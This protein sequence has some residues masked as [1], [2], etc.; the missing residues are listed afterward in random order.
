MMAIA[1]LPRQSNSTHPAEWTIP[2]LENVLGGSGVPLRVLR[3][4]LDGTDREID[5]G[6]YGVAPPGC[7]L[8]VRAPHGLRKAGVLLEP[9]R[10]VEN[11]AP[12]R[13]LI[14]HRPLLT[15]SQC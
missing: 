12:S 4:G 5:T 3:V 13:Y 1:V 10:I 2:I 15:A 6:E 11:V 8:L 14:W 7:N 9:T